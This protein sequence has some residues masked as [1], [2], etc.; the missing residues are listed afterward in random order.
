M[1]T[2]PNQI[3]GLKTISS[4]F[5]AWSNKW[6]NPFTI[7]ITILTI[8]LIPLIKFWWN[9]R[10]KIKFVNTSAKL[11][12][13][14][15][16]DINFANK[17]EFKY[18][19]SVSTSLYNGCPGMTFSALSSYLL[20]YSENKNKPDVVKLQ[21]SN[22]INIPPATLSSKIT[23]EAN[24]KEEVEK[25]IFADFKYA[26][27]AIEGPD[28]KYRDYKIKNISRNYIDNLKLEDIL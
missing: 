4:S 17:E 12:I 24:I 2:V 1:S 19:L 22:P 26:V 28:E 25:R 20:I 21:T 11:D 9:N 10:T 14:A 6:V 7:I 27:F 18:K 5:L 8:I 15:N 16:L 23:F 13:S 3:F